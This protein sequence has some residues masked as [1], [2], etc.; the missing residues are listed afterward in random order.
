MK[1]VLTLELKTEDGVEFEQELAIG[2]KEDPDEKVRVLL[3]CKNLILLEMEPH[4]ELVRIKRKKK[5]CLSHDWKVKGDHYMCRDCKIP[6]IK[7]HPFAKITPKFID[8]KY[9][10]C[11]WKLK[12]EDYE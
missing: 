4:I 1:R 5:V 2:L 12:L 9:K 11:G 10:D 6:G 3:L 7:E 8:P